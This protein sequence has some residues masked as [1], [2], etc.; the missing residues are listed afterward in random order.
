MALVLGLFR[1][2]QDNYT[3][4]QDQAYTY[5]CSQIGVSDAVALLSPNHSKESWWW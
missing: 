3:T 1:W 5:G 4:Y 2:C